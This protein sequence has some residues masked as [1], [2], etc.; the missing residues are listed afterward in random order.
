MTI[1]RTTLSQHVAQEIIG[2][3]KLRG[4]RTGDEIPA[5][6]ELAERHG[7]NRLAVREAIRTLVARGVL[8][9]SQGK[10]AR[11]AVPAPAVLE[12]ILDFRLSQ[13]SMDLADL[14][15]TRRVIEAELAR[16]AAVRRAAG[17]G[18]M[19]EVDRALATMGHAVGEPE[20]FIAAD[21]AFHQA[22]AE[23]AASGLFS[24]ILTA[25][26]GILLDSRRASY[27]GRERRGAGQEATVDAHRRIADAIAGGDGNRAAEAMTAH[28]AE[29]GHDL[30]L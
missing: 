10:R 8:V 2:E 9:S 20:A 18:S 28:L 25:M 5:E 3:I 27:H 16:R 24:F 12:Q 14:L 1:G 17:E 15:D 23:L 19:T 21:L 7:V 30:G 13:N 4:L 29:T 22:V 6:G 26:N 11:V